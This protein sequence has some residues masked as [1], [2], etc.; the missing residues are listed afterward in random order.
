MSDR[1]GHRPDGSLNTIDRVGLATYKYTVFVKKA[2]FEGCK[3]LGFHGENSESSLEK[4]FQN[5]SDSLLFKVLCQFVSCEI[6][7]SL[8]STR[9]GLDSDA[10]TIQFDCPSKAG[11]ARLL[12]MSNSIA[13]AIYGV[14]ETLKLGFLPKLEILCNGQP[15]IPRLSPE[16][17]VSDNFMSSSNVN[18]SISSAEL[19]DL[20]LDLNEL[21]R[22][23][24][25]V[26]ITQ[27]FDQKVLFANQSALQSNNRAA[28]EMVGKEITALW[29]D[30]VL[31]Q[32]IG[33]LERDRQLW[34]YS[35][36]GYRWSRDPNSR[37]WRRDRYMFVANYKLVE[38]LGSIC[39]FCVITSAEKI[40][41]PVF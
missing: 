16:K 39:R 2:S 33:R 38:F 19:A 21:Y 32:L 5:S 10:K 7:E 35:Y 22:D 12:R 37:I 15:F 27:M 23:R 25:P 11:A 34:Q 14:K 41:T 1:P 18:H 26:Y 28:G 30:D 40:Q 17:L 8:T 13:F 20:D 9:I 3:M 31:S 24:D 36:P 6:Q 4:T 29:D